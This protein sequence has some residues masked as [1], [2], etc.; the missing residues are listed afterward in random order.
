[1]LRNPKSLLFLHVWETGSDTDMG[2]HMGMCLAH[3]EMV[4]AV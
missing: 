3:V 2:Y 1:M 4:L